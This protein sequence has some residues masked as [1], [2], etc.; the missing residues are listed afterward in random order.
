MGVILEAIKLEDRK[1]VALKL[2][3][4]DRPVTPDFRSRFKRETRILLELKHPNVI[5]YID[6]NDARGILWL[7][8]EYVEGGYDIAAH[9]KHHRGRIPLP[10][11]VELALQSLEGLAFAHCV[12][13]VVHRDIK[14][15]NILL[16]GD[17]RRRTAK[18]SDFG[19]A[20]SLEDAG[21]N[22]S[23]MTKPAV[24]MGTLPYMP[25][26]QAI[27]VR[28]ATPTADVF[29]MGATLYEMVTG[30]HV[31]D[32]SR[33]QNEAIRQ[34][35]QDPVV[36]IRERDP[37]IPDALAAVIDKSVSMDPGARYADARAF[38]NALEKA[39]K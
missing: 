12:K 15:A 35:V 28:T 23:I 11:A 27:D 20:K 8:M 26:E 19:L 4:P 21:L 17:D 16:P 33:V 36:P 14:P 37:A 24:C 30:R 29:S 32:F 25:P 1:K 22:G 2:I 18:V 7:A 13:H 34:V 10:E 39:A 3:R 38:K 5:T 6:G 9:M 31:R